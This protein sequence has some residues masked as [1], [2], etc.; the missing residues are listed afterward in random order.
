MKPKGDSNERVI[1]SVSINKK[2]FPL[3]YEAV[4]SKGRSSSVNIGYFSSISG[5]LAA[6]GEK[7][8]SAPQNRVEDLIEKKFDE[9]FQKL[10]SLQVS[11]AP[12]SQPEELDSDIEDGIEFNFT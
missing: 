2:T 11:A 4:T 10:N 1:V 9:L 7:E 12:D 6:A 8:L 3:L 5:F